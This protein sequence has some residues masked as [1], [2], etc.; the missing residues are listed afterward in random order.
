MDRLQRS[1]HRLLWLNPLAG[2]PHYQPLVRG[3]QA[4]LPYVDEFLPIHNLESLE[5]VVRRL[6]QPTVPRATPSIGRCLR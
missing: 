5:A 1:C 6:G 4:A 2:A 3:M